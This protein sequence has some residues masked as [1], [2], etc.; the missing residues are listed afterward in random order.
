MSMQVTLGMFKVYPEVVLLYDHN[1]TLIELH[2]EKRYFP[3]TYL[4]HPMEVRNLGKIFLVKC[5]GTST[6]RSRKNFPWLSEKRMC[7]RPS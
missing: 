5:V 1:M 6:G 4:G 3:G 7:S 2:C